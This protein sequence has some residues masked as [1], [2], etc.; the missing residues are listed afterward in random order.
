MLYYDIKVEKESMSFLQTKNLFTSL[1]AYM[2]QTHGSLCYSE[3]QTKPRFG[4][5]VFVT[6]R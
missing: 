3:V 2:L 4:C 6:I 1:F 5:F